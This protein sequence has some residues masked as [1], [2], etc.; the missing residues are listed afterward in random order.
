M[1]FSCLLLAVFFSCLLLAVL[2]VPAVGYAHSCFL[3]STDCAWYTARPEFFV[4]LHVLLVELDCWM[5]ALLVAAL[6]TGA[7]VELLTLLRSR[8]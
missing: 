6:V 3:I 7:V 5:P 2:F 1:I 4:S 8:W